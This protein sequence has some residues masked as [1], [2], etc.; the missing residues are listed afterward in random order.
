[1]S[2]KAKIVAAAATFALAGGGLG[3]AGTL[4][5]SAATRRCGRGCSDVYILKFGPRF[6]LDTFQRRAA[7]GQEVILFQASSSDPALD[8]VIKDLG[9]VNSLSTMGRHR[10]IT[11]RFKAWYGSFHAYEFQY[12]P[13]GR[14]SHFCASTWPGVIA[15]PGYKVRLATC[16]KYSNSIWAAGPT[17]H[18]G[19]A[20]R[21][22]P[23][24]GYT[25]FINGATDS[26]S[27]P[28]VLNYPAG[29]PTDRP[30][31]CLN[32]QPLHAHANGAVFGNQQWSATPGPVHG[33]M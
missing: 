19:I 6:L 15:Q 26:F 10:L 25:F 3:T 4:S 11:R 20:I 14:N 2:L 27:H 30:R 1:M 23:N 22:V 28:L 16:G 17:P 13:H 7:A 9:T 18:Q 5:A 31:P 8:F 21:D 12:A 32:V 29:V 24:H 33:R